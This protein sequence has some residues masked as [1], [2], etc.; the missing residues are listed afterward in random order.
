METSKNNY[1]FYLSY[2]ESYKLLKTDKEK[3]EYTELI[4][5]IHFFEVHID[6]VVIKNTAVKLLFASIKHSLKSSI[7]GYCDKKGI[8]YNS[9]FNDDKNDPSQGG[10]QGAT[11]PPSQEIVISNK[12]L[13][14]NNK[15]PKKYKSELMSKIIQEDFEKFYSNYPRKVGRG[16]AEKAFAKLNAN[17]QQKVI[18]FVKTDIFQNYMSSQVSERG[19]FRP[20]PASWLNGKR[21]E[22][23][24]TEV[25]EKPVF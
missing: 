23:D 9:L 17:E 22:D 13:V 11:Q 6:R 24:L 14:I 5:K 18:A 15:Q 2:W 21:W 16:N 25:E 3:V 20:H 19:D 7:Q 12:Q 10:S 4:N 1:K 8:D